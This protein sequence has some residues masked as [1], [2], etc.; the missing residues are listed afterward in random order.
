VALERSA[1][2]AAGT[3][4]GRGLFANNSGTLVVSGTGTSINSTSASALNV[5]NTDFGA[6]GATFQSIASRNN[7]AAAD[8]ANGIV[9]NNTVAAPT[10]P[11]RG[12]GGH[13]R[14]LRLG[15]R[16]HDALP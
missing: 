3:S 2:T 6:A 13:P 15:R 9:L 1:I 10:R 14:G 7:S 5:A 11:T 12:P 8:P 4:T 16:R